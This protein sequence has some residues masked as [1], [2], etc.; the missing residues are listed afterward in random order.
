MSKN[1][2]FTQKTKEILKALKAKNLTEIDQ[3]GILTP[4]NHTNRVLPASV[5]VI[6]SV[7]ESPHG[8]ISVYEFTEPVALDIN[9][10]LRLQHILPAEKIHK[11]YTPLPEFERN[12]V[13][14][15]GRRNIYDKGMDLFVQADKVFYNA[16]GPA[17]FN[18]FGFDM[19]TRKHFSASTV[20]RV[21][22]SIMGNVGGF[23]SIAKEIPY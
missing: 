10:S 23:I 15:E 14:M 2:F 19:E 6:V 1:T 12:T 17:G 4:S 3:Y 7:A 18:E 8:I 5:Y 9:Y 22:D 20:W 11:V 16:L 13:G 21:Q